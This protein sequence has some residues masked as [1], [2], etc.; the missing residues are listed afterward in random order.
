MMTPFDAFQRLVGRVAVALGPEW[1]PT[2]EQLVKMGLA[3]ARYAECHNRLLEM[4]A[5]SRSFWLSGA[6]Q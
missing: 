6:A 4:A 2:P 5:E 1:T 3:S